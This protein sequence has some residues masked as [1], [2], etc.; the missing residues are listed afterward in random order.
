[1][2]SVPLLSRSL[3]VEFMNS[4]NFLTILDEVR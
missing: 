2:S 4:F 1:V 3:L